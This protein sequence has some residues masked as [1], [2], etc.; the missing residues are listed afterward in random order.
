MMKKVILLSWL[1]SLSAFVAIA[2]NAA[3]PNPGFENWTQQSNYWNPNSWNNLNSSTYILGVFTCQRASA[4]ADVHS[5]SYAIKLTTKSVFGITANGIASTATLITTP[6]YGITGGIP[7]T[8]RPDSI[9]GW[10]K[11]TPANAN[12]SGFVQ[13]ALLTN[14]YDTIGMVKFNTPNTPVTSYTRFSKAITYLSPATPELS[15]WIL[16]ASDGVNPVVN[17][18]LIVDDIDLIFVTTPVTGEP[19][20]SPIAPVSNL[21]QE[22][23]VIKNPSEKQVFFELTDLSGRM[24]M[25]EEITHHRQ[26]ISSAMLNNGIYIYRLSDLNG[27]VHSSGKVIRY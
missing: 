19:V 5:G 4:A 22:E 23:I 6:P 24:V 20:K 2:Q 7:Y 25:R 16:S 21:V 9:V 1:L 27:S 18:V 8:D 17:S 3:T 11:Y 12:D 15:Y 10:Y 26:S 13:F 14:N